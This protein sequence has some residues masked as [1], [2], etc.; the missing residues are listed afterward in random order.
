M[1]TRRVM[2]CGATA[3]A[4][5]ASDDYEAVLEGSRNNEFHVLANDLEQGAADR[6]S[7]IVSVSDTSLGGLVTI[8]RDGKA[9]LFTPAVGSHADDCFTYT[10]DGVQRATVWVQVVTRARDDSYHVAPRSTD[11]NLSV[12][13]NDQL[14]P[15]YAGTGR[16]TQV[17][18]GDQGGTISVSGDG[19]SILYSPADGF[20][21]TESFRY[22]LDGGF[23]AQVQVQVSDSRE[24]LYPRFT[25]LDQL[26]EFLIQDAL[27]RYRDV[28]GQPIDASW[29]TYDMGT[30]LRNGVELPWTVLASADFASLTAGGHGQT[31]QQIA[32]VQEGDIVET[33]DR[34]LYVLRDNE[35]I[36]ALA[37]PANSL[38]V[39]SRTRFEHRP[40]AMYLNSDRL[41]VISDGSSGGLID[42]TLPWQG[43]RLGPLDPMFPSAMR[44][45]TVVSVLDVT[46]R[47]GPAMMQQTKLDGAYRDSRAMGN[48]VFVTLMHGELRL[49]APEIIWAN[50]GAS[51]PDGRGTYESEEVYLARMEKRIGEILEDLLPQYSSYDG[52]GQWIR[53]GLV[54]IPEELYRPVATDG[55]Q[56]LSIVSLDMQGQSAGMVASSSLLGTGAAYIMGS[57]DSLYVFDHAYSEDETFTQITKFAWNE[58]SGTI[59]FAARGS[60]VGALNS[61]FAADEYEGDLRIATSTWD[62]SPG[63]GT[64]T[65]VTDVWVLREDLGI[66]EI[67][68]AARNIAPGETMQS[69]RFAGDRGFIVT[70]QNIDPLFALDLSDPTRPQVLGELEIPGFSTYLHFVDENHLLGIGVDAGASGSTALALFD[71]SDPMQPELI[72]RYVFGSDWQWSRAQHDPR[73]FGWFEEL[74]MLTIPY[75][76]GAWLEIDADADGIVDTTEWRQRTGLAVFAIDTSFHE[77]SDLGVQLEG[78]VDHG[79]EV[80][81]GTYIEQVLYS[82]STAG[83]KAVEIGDLTHVIAEVE[84]G[85]A[86]PSEPGI[87]DSV[88][89]TT[90]N[91]RDDQRLAPI[92]A[93]SQTRLGSELGCDANQL[94]LVAA[95]PTP[96]GLDLVFHDGLKQ[97][98]V[99]S[100]SD[101]SSHVQVPEFEFVTDGRSLSWHNP[102]VPNDVNGDGAVSPL[103]ALTVINELWPHGGRALVGTV[104]LRSIALSQAARLPAY[105][106]V[107]NDGY[108]APLDALRVINELSVAA[109][110]AEDRSLA[111]PASAAQCSEIVELDSTGIIQVE[112][113]P[114]RAESAS[115]TVR[116]WT[117][118]RTSTESRVD[119]ADRDVSQVDLRTGRHAPGPRPLT[120]ASQDSH[121]RTST[122]A[123]DQMFAQFEAVRT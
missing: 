78:L 26:Q 6:N 122:H 67:I 66:L 108:V 57:P 105:V 1:E 53:S 86:Q 24:D 59:E 31:N 9:L 12:L 91:P 71:V 8:A 95:E 16:I 77:P 70:F 118:W 116:A 103:D 27:D 90:P 17:A 89:R 7:V 62:G 44:T 88:D 99:S 98:F 60:V 113:L 123:L 94:V 100:E 36:I 48:H 55:R 117:P 112:T 119:R 96:N 72:D 106:D 35:L 2:D 79:D 58:A 69:V 87:P 5:S 107:N 111:V 37:S 43:P 40:V 18:A 97:Y 115:A 101:G 20:Q 114:H 85:D 121:V 49:P 54:T 45:S 10:V 120:P 65:P 64:A 14:G 39:V 15:G 84:F 50:D 38:Q 41:T 13:L 25:S 81:R 32:G 3:N 76:S 29:G 33:D 109:R 74:G 30:I 51:G 82:V 11:N 47:N 22:T 23:S 21:G 110:P 104:P 93:A 4:W 102:T 34:Y 61:Q 56:M 42:W 83:I 68:G 92:I 73:A 80:L 46:D 19:Y 75:T 63:D 52:Q 28:F